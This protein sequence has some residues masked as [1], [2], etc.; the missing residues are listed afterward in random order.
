LPADK[1]SISSFSL[2]S[3]A[4]LQVVKQ[5]LESPYPSDP[6]LAPAM[7]EIDQKVFQKTQTLYQ[8]CMNETLIDGQGIKPILSL[9]K[10]IKQRISHQDFVSVLS[11]VH[12]QDTSALFDFG[13]EIDDKNP[14]QNSIQ[15]AQGGLNLP[16]KEYYEDKALIAF[17]INVTQEM[18]A[19]VWPLINITDKD[20]SVRAKNVIGLES[21]LAV[22]SRP[23][24]A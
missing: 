15:L 21:K 24:Y 23:R 1:S 16:S 13:V 7:S 14:S 12:L 10:Q 6:S 9:L 22:Y 3:D 2:L 8:S 5:I 4:N 17:Y 20:F 19:F 18:M 11:F